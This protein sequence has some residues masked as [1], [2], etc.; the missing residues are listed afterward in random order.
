[1]ICSTQINSAFYQ[2]PNSCVMASYGIVSEYF[3]NNISVSKIFEEYCDFFRIPYLNSIN[4]EIYCGNHLNFVCQ[5]ILHWRGYEMTNYIDNHSN[6]N[7]VFIQNRSLF[8]AKIVSLTPLNTAQYQNLLNDLS[9]K[10]SLA[11]ILTVVNGGYHSRTIGI[12]NN[13]LFIHDTNPN[14]NPRLTSNISF[15]PTDILECIYYEKI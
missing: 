10:E 15:K 12:D 9:S 13:S 11:N 4:A 6:N 7:Q 14:V 8:R 1:M 2:Q 3:N 5:N